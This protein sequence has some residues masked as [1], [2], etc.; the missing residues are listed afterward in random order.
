MFKL[1]YSAEWIVNRNFDLTFFIGSFSASLFFLAL[2]FLFKIPVLIL[3][4]IFEIFFDG[5]HIFQTATRTYLDKEEFNSNKIRYIFSFLILVMLGTLLVFT[6]NI[7]VWISIFIYWG[8]YHIAKQHYGFVAIYKIKNKDNINFDK[9]LDKLTL[10]MLLFTIF[11]FGLYRLKK[12]ENFKYYLIPDIPYTVVALLIGLSLLVVLVFILRQIYVGYKHKVDIPKILLMA[13]AVLSYF[14]AF[15]FLNDFFMIHIFI[16]T[17][18]AVQYNG[19]VW[20]Y[21]INKY[22]HK[23]AT[24]NKLVAYMSQKRNFLIYFGIVLFIGILLG[25]LN[26]ISNTNTILLVIALAITYTHFYIDGKIWIFDKYPSI[27]R[28]LN[29]A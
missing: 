13:T 8:S 9:K 5:A 24:G 20:F 4:A 18:H 17:F 7:W 25:N 1:N 28:Y 10:Y 14:I 23:Q 16:T 11:V 6:N 21:N 26:V 12:L 27:K 19:L 3:F 15:K 29:L 2:Y 22:S